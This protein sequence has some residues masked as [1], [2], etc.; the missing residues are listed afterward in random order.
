MRLLIE[1]DAALKILSKVMGVVKSKPETPIGGHVLLTALATTLS[2]ATTNGDQQAVD[3]AP[4][5]IEEP[6]RT[7]VDARRL[8]DVIRNLPEGGEVLLSMAEDGTRLTV[9]CGKVRATLGA[10]PAE[11]FPEFPAL[12]GAAGGALPRDE[13]RRLLTRTRFA[14]S[15]DSTRPELGGTYIHV[16]EHDGVLWLTAVALDLKILAMADMQAPAHFA[17]FPGTILAG[18][19]V[20]EVSRLLGDGPDVVELYASETLAEF[21]S[22]STEITSKVIEPPYPA[23]VNAIQRAG[24]SL[25][26]KIDAE[27]L[28][29]SIN[30]ALLVADDKYRT[31]RLGL[32]PD[33]LTITARSPSAGDELNDEIAIDYAGPDADLSFNAS[34]IKSLFGAIRGEN[35][36]C[37]FNAD[38]PKKNAILITDSA[39]PFCRY[40][41]TQNV[42]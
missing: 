14:C 13:L 4:A 19:F 34:R 8:H 3:C 12:D 31:V 21:R 35:A 38:D 26:V 7:T 22:G 33:L 32:S 23:Y 6:G 10:L 28:V 5:K 37:A 9:K 39:D 16:R 11:D 1:R 20:D 2:V 41:L 17:G 18:P 40:V 27:L 15:S 25:V 29:T 42:G 24:G 30:R 36:L